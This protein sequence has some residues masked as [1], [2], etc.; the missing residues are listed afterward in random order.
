MVQKGAFPHMPHHL[1]LLNNWQLRI[2]GTLLCPFC[3][4]T[5]GISFTNRLSYLI[6]I[7]VKLQLHAT[8]FDDDAISVPMFSSVSLLFN[9]FLYEL[10]NV[11][12]GLYLDGWLL[13]DNKCYKLGH[14]GGVQAWNWR[15]KILT[16]HKTWLS[17][18]EPENKVQSKLW[19]WK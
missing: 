11:K 9:W 19:L 18:C 15:L 1:I 10:S 12:P 3:A 16:G 8:I 7:T 14:V 13:E 6:W 4:V 2:T 5:D 17:Q